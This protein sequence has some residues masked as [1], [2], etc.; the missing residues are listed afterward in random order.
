MS[1][2]RVIGVGVCNWGEII[3]FAI[4]V[5]IVAVVIALTAFGVIR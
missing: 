3:G 5:I 2:T 1:D 4:G